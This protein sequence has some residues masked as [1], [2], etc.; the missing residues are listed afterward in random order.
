MAWARDRRVG[1][2]AVVVAAVGV[3]IGLAWG[4]GDAGVGDLVSANTGAATRQHAPHHDGR[5]RAEM[6]RLFDAGDRATWKA[7]FRFRRRV[8][9]GGQ[10]HGTMTE[11][12]RPPDHLTSAFGTLSGEYHGQEVA[13]SKTAETVACDTLPPVRDDE[14]PA[15]ALASLVA[16]T[17]TPH[18]VYAVQEAGSHSIAGERATC[19]RLVWTGRV[20]IQPYGRNSEYCFAR[21]GVPVRVS[22]EHDRA[23]DVREASSI[24]RVV[25]DADVESLLQPYR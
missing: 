10:L 15:A 11:L 13:C 7:Q 19:F 20:R 4:D 25:T 18:R 3:V 12:N 17:A 6:L 2:V 21:D 16:L 8:T 9:S 23:V 24:D 14:G 5:A 1:A 22:L